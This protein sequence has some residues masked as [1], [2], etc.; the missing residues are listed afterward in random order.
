MFLE[1]LVHRPQWM[2]W[3]ICR[4]EPT[5]TFFPLRGEDS[6]P[7]KA[8]CARCPVQTE[9]LEHALANDQVAG[10]QLQGIW[11]GKSGRERRT[12]LQGRRGRQA[13]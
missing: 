3:G 11:G 4:D 7:A 10:C 1:E 2:A 5:E 12:I 13:A 6:R 9:C 8:V